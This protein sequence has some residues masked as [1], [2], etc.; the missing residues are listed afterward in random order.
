MIKDNSVFG[1]GKLRS[2]GEYLKGCSSNK[3]LLVTDRSSF[4]LLK[5]RDVILNELGKYSYK[6]YADFDA[7]PNIKDL[8]KGLKIGNE[9]DPDVVIGVGGGSVLD[10]AKMIALF[11]DKQI[12]ISDALSGNNKFKKRRRKLILIPTTAGTGSEATRFA[13]LYVDKIKHSISSDELLPDHVI[14]DSTLTD[15]MGKYLT[16]VTMF[17]CFSQAIESF[18]A[19]GSTEESRSYSRESIDLVLDNYTKIIEDPDEDSRD[20]LLRASYLAGKAINISKTT[21]PHAIS[22]GITQYYGIPHGHAVAMTLG[23]FLKY[24]GTMDLEKLNAGL[25]P[26]SYRLHYSELLKA[27]RVET[28]DEAMLKV[29]EMM[30]YSGLKTS[31]RDIGIKTKKEISYLASIVNNERLMNNPMKINPEELETLLQI[32][33]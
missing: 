12:S 23:S 16:A 1:R 30:N 27:L 25:D 20:K 14:L 10:T 6:Q 15:T 2:I 17:D 33:Y 13:V 18:W 24:N 8:R 11:D 31:F 5:G 3:I 29:N 4:D 21:A 9:Y 28:A 26:K 7:N 32:L 22:Y 19:V